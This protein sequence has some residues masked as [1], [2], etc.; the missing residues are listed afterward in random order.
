MDRIVSDGKDFFDQLE[1]ALIWNVDG[2]EADRAL[3]VIKST[4][5]LLATMSKHIAAGRWQKQQKT[6]DVSLRRDRFSFSYNDVVLLLC[7][8]VEFVIIEGR[9]HCVIL[10]TY[11]ST[12]KRVKFS[13]T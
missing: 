4:E 7:H 13:V 3:E 10:K 6:T 11:K 9:C 2:V 12:Q 5:L 1:R 8:C